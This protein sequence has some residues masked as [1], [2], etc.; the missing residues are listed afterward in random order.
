MIRGNRGSYPARA[1]GRASDPIIAECNVWHQSVGAHQTSQEG[2]R[3]ISQHCWQWAIFCMQQKKQV[4]WLRANLRDGGYLLD[5]ESSLRKTSG[6]PM[7]CEQ[8]SNIRNHI[9]Q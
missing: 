3:G 2:V 4:R 6:P 8:E 5:D 9:Y 1:T 7:I